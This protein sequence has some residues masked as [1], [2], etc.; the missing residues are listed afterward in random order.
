VTV[1][2]WVLKSGLESMKGRFRGKDIDEA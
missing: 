2:E 1:R